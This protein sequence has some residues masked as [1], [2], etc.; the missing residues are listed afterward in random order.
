MRKIILLLF[1]L[2]SQVSM[3]QTTDKN[4]HEKYHEF[5]FWIGK[6]DVYKI[7]ADK[8]AGKSEIES[9]IDSVG[10]LENY[11]TPDGKYSGKSLNKYNPAKD[12]W[13]QYWIDNSGLTLYLVGG[14]VDDK[15]ILDD[16]QTGDAKAGFNQIIWQ[17]LPNGEVQQTWNASTD[18]GKTWTT[19]FDGIYKKIKE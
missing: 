18:N 13:E 10:I 11:V 8:I 7:G 4:V 1:I 9:I 14:I 17:K 15:M 3:A 2:N 12:R 16:L 6:W 5:D 19:L